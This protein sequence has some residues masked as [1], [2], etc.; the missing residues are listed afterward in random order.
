MTVNKNHLINTIKLSI[1]K[2]Q[3]ELIDTYY[4]TYEEIKLTSEL[5]LHYLNDEKIDIAIQTMYKL[6]ESMDKNLWSD[7]TDN[8]KNVSLYIMVLYN[9][10]KCLGLSGKYKEAVS[11]CETAQDY[12]LKTNQVKNLPLILLNKACCLCDQGDV[13]EGIKEL[14]IAYYGCLMTK[15][16]EEVEEI[17]EYAHE[18]KLNIVFD[19]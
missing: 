9:L 13:E 8:I 4:L 11:L 15:R 12:C 6:K 1:P 17:K 7:N 14:R 19:Q 18:K 5:A 2:F 16:D 3:E 10:T